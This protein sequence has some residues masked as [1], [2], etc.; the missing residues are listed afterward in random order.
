[1]RFLNIFVP[2]FVASL[3]ASMGIPPQAEAKPIP[4]PA[5]LAPLAQEEPPKVDYSLK[6]NELVMVPV[7]V[8]LLE[9]KAL[10]LDETNPDNLMATDQRF[11]KGVRQFATQL[12]PKQTLKLSLKATPIASYMVNWV[13]PSDKKHPM[14]TKIKLG[15]DAQLGR[16]NPIM[17]IK[18]TTKEQ[19]SVFFVVYGPAGQPYSLKV[20]RK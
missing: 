2:L 1:M 7:G 12:E 6:G 18:N 17:T 4:P 19:C 20:E 16:R 10:P 14:Y 13:L 8:G 15:Y 11:A 9:E 5:P 3:G